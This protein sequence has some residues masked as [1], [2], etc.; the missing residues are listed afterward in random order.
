MVGPGWK[1]LLLAPVLLAGIAC[2]ESTASNQTPPPETPA[3]SSQEAA[4][5]SPSSSPVPSL[6]QSA[7]AAVV[8]F[9]NAPVAASR[10][11]NATL[12]ASTSPNTSC[13]IEVDYKSGPSTAAGLVPKTSDASGHVSWTWKVGS[14]T[15]PGSWPITVTCGGATAKTYISV[16]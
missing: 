14:N 11:Q 10:G 2:A 16:T 6:S 7:V 4:S 8:T 9:A 3:S 12:Q 15:T 5:P 1:A 13:G